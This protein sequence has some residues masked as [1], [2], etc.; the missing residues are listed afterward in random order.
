MSNIK[1]FKEQ[2]E[3]RLPL[4][5]LN[6][7]ERREYYKTRYTGEQLEATLISHRLNDEQLVGRKELFYIVR[8]LGE[9]RVEARRVIDDNLVSLE[10][11]EFER[12]SD[13]IPIFKM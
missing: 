7:E 11:L 3:R 5:V 10:N 8:L 4:S 9:H 1:F 6:I 13:N 12:M 2:R